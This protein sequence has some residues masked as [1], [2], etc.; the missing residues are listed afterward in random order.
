VVHGYSCASVH[1]F[2]GMSDGM[3][4]I[5]D[6]FIRIVIASNFT[7]KFAPSFWSICFHTSFYQI[8]AHMQQAYRI[9][10]AKNSYFKSIVHTASKETDYFFPIKR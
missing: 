4:D 5:A 7:D 10:G 3:A 1:Y 2:D 9:L 6:E 8:A